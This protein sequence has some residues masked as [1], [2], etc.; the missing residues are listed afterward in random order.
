[1]DFSRILDFLRQH[2]PL[3]VALPFLIIGFGYLFL[4]TLF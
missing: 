4:G 1:M 3:I 2:G